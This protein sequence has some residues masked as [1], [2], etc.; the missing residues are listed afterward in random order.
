M[1]AEVR[2]RSHQP[3]E[4]VGEP[5]FHT[6]RTHR[7]RGEDCGIEP[8]PGLRQSAEGRLGLLVPGHVRAKPLDAVVPRSSRGVDPID[9]EDEIALRKDAPHHGLA[10]SPGRAGEEEHTSGR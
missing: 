8:A 10:D 9:G 6:A 2:L 3:S 1:K 4:R 7:A 5:P